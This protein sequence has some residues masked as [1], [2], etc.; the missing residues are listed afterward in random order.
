MIKI[1]VISDT[2]LD[3]VT[4]E[5]K[6]NIV[7]YFNDADMIIHSGDMTVRAVYEYLSNWNLKAVRGNMDDFD[8]RDI[9][10]EKRVVEI[11]GIKIGIMHGRGSPNGLSSLVFKEFRGVDIIVFGH[12]HIPF[13]G[14]NGN[15]E[16]FNPG[17]YKGSYGQPGSLGMVEIG[18]DLKFRHIELK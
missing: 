13:H 9:L 17:S 2:H 11:S 15:V 7:K 14:K 4:D 5:F 12:S 18:N 16:M 1:G 3:R 6:D 8:L 10:P